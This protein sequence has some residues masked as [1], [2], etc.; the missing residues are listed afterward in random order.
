MRRL[1]AG[2]RHEHVAPARGQ[3]VGNV[4]ADAPPEDARD[5]LLEQQVLDQLGLGLM[6]RSGHAHQLPAR[7]LRPDLA[8]PLV[9]IARRRLLRRAAAEDERHAA[10]T[11]EASLGLVLAAAG[12]TYEGATRRRSLLPRPCRRRCARPERSARP[13]ATRSGTASAGSR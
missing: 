13:R 5:A 11:A 10:V 1:G 12:R 8:R 2:L 4:E 7:V 6:T 3:E 9:R